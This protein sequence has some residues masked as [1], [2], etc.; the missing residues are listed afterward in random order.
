MASPFIGEIRMAGF[1]FAPTGWALCD[2]TL[3]PRSQ[4]GS[5]F[6]ILDYRFG[7]SGALFALPDLQ[8]A[9]P[10]GAGQGSGLSPR[11]LGESGGSATV[12]LTANEIPSHR[13]TASAST[14]LTGTVAS[15]SGNRW[16]QVRYGRGGLQAFSA[17]TNAQMAS[18]ALATT[19][20]GS[21][22]NNLPPYLTISF[23]IA[24]TGVFPS[25]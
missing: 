18:A 14:A 25:P 15:P 1:T 19:G 23:C 20:S 7:G 6:T 2:G 8:G 24:L 21:G 11:N 17:S 4:N 9:V 3:L 16:A 22:H 5:L 12:A 13:H 10:L